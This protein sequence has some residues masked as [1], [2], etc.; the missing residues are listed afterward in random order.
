MKGLYFIKNKPESFVCFWIHH[1]GCKKVISLW[2]SPGSCHSEKTNSNAFEL[3]LLNHQELF[4]VQQREHSHPKTLAH[5]QKHR[6]RTEAIRWLVGGTNHIHPMPSLPSW[7][8]SDLLDLP[9]LGTKEVILKCVMWWE[10]LRSANEKHNCMW[11][12][13]ISSKGFPFFHWQSC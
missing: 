7:R 11:I 4:L 12:L 5:P 1:C 13:R 9:G 3:T 6:E 8:K 2:L 10:L